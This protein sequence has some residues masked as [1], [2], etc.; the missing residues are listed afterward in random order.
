MG[1]RMTFDQL[2]QLAQIL[3]VVL[4]AVSVF[5]IWREVRETARLTRANNT[6]KMTES[7]SAFYL[8]IAQDKEVAAIWEQ[9]SNDYFSLADIDRY[10]YLSLMNWWLNFYENIY[11]QQRGKLLDESYFQAWS[12]ELHRLV[13]APSFTT[14]WNEMRESY[15]ADFIRYVEQILIH[16]GKKQSDARTD[17]P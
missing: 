13:T 3:N 1:N 11:L 9:G 7:S 12:R 6:H 8:L 4:V 16:T 14:I 17:R 15:S 2:A 5:F 10:R